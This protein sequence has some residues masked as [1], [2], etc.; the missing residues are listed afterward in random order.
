MAKR[1]RK[2][3][4]PPTIW[5]VPDELWERIKPILDTR[6]ENENGKR[7][8]SNYGK[9]WTCPVFSA[10]W[11][12]T[13]CNIKRSLILL[14]MALTPVRTAGV[15]AISARRRDEKQRVSLKKRVNQ[16]GDPARNIKTIERGAG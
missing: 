16:A 9:Y 11:M 15:S 2:D 1:K 5:H 8:R 3:E 10:V 6:T 7:D 14:G 12:A 13:A 4:P